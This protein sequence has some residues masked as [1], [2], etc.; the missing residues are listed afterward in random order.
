MIIGKMLPKATNYGRLAHSMRYVI[1]F[2]KAVI[3]GM[4]G[5]K[6][7]MKRERERERER[8]GEGEGEGGRERE[9]A[10]R[11]GGVGGGRQII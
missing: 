7:N 3:I 6:A 1:F 11:W 8:G 9:R 2:Y 10:G 4:N 5:V